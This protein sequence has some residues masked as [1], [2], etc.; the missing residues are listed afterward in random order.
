[1]SAQE[2]KHAFETDAIGAIGKFIQG[3]GDAEKHGSSAIEMLN[4]MGIKEG[5]LRDSLLR[6]ANAQDLFKNAIARG[7]KAFNENTALTNEANKRYETT[8]SKLKILKNELTETAIKFG[9]PL[10][11]AIRN[12]VKAG[13]PYLQMLSKM[14]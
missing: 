12:G 3:L 4:E 11:D 10:L 8:A 7:N 14:A 1:M 2:F 6:A 5:R 13:E 9:G